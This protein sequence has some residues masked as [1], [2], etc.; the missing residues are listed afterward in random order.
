VPPVLAGPV[1]Q[2]VITNLLTLASQRRLV[3]DQVTAIGGFLF[4]LAGE[5]MKPE[6]RIVPGELPERISAA[7]VSFLTGKLAADANIDSILKILE[8]V[9]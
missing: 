1:L 7:A 3:P 5:A 8:R 9:V 2:D 4:A 6:G